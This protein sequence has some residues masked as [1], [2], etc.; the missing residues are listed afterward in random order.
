MLWSSS[1]SL[2]AVA[3]RS[4]QGWYKCGARE[5]RGVVEGPYLDAGARVLDLGAEREPR[6]PRPGALAHRPAHVQRDEQREEG[7]QAT[8]CA[9]GGVGVG[10]VLA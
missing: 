10:L 4:E 1:T 7:A 3:S 8:A 2:A 6:P 9:G 5:L